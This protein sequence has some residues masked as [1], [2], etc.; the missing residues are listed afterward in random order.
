MKADNKLAV[1]ANAKQNP[2]QAKPPSA[3]PGANNAKP[4]SNTAPG[5][6][7]LPKNAKGQPI[8]IEEEVK[9]PPP[10]EKNLERFIYITTYEDIE[11][12]KILKELFENINREAL[13]FKS[14]KEIY[15]QTLTPEQQDDNLLDFISGFQ[16]IDTNLRIT[17]I[18]GRGDKAMQIV[19]QRLPKVDLNSKLKKVFANSKILFDKRFYSKF[20][21][22]LKF[23]KLRTNLNEILT[24][25]D[26]YMKAT[27]Y[28]EIY[29]AFMNL[30]AI[31]QSSSFQSITECKLFPE[32]ESLLL[33]ERKYADI[34]NDQDLTGVKQEQKTKR[35]RIKAESLDKSSLQT[36][37]T[38]LSY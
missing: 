4:G 20:N 7:N 37:N 29:S 35:K 22:C 11:T 8:I 3:K 9:P 13:N 28:K 16:I 25:A 17:V 31:M 26:I 12:M 19:K 21:L 30:G 38:S 10:K 33:L 27:K 2:A 14:V 34:L 24:T 36:N 6:K 23:I 15:T 5:N 1:N 32:A 18:E